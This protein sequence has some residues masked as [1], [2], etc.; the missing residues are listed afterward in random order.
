MKRYSYDTLI[1]CR[2]YVLCVALYE[3][4]LNFKFDKLQTRIKKC[5]ILKIIK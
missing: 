2:I 4:T 1:L 5:R 3:L